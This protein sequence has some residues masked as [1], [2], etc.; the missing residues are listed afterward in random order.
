M[1]ISKPESS[2]SDSWTCSSSASAVSAVEFLKLLTSLTRTPLSIFSCV[3]D[4][5]CHC[6]LVCSASSFSVILLCFC[7]FCYS[8]L[9]LLFLL[10]C[11]A[12]ALSVILLLFLFLSFFS[13][14]VLRFISLCTFAKSHATHPLFFHLFLKVNFP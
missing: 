4:S 6:Y 3:D 1:F 7:S 14:S 11:S 5:P 8:A 12:S 2:F 9:L 13:A 10:F